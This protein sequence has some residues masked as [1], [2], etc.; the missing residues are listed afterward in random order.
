[1]HDFTHCAGL[2][3]GFVFRNGKGHLTRP[4]MPLW[5]KG[6]TGSGYTFASIGFCLALFGFSYWLL[7]RFRILP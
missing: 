1:M 3:F 7:R 5:A 2:A 6:R 4:C